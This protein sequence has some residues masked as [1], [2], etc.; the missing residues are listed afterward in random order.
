MK[1]DLFAFAYVPQW[2]EHLHELASMALPESWRFKYPSYETRNQDTPLLERYINYIFRKQ[3]I[4]YT[5]EDNPV[6]ADQRFY[7]R[8][9]VCCFHTGLLSRR[10]KSIYGYFVRN[11]KRIPCLTGTS[12][13][14]WKR[15]HR[16]FGT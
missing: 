16:F 6:R 9:E 5:Y 10:Y 15:P 8:N 1:S 2:F 4:E 14:L 12:R 7:M 11:K 13:A 3:I